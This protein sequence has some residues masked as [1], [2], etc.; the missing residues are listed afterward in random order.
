[1]TATNHRPAG[2]TW[3]SGYQFLGPLRSHEQ[4]IRGLPAT[5]GIASAR[6]C[7]TEWSPILGSTA[8]LSL[9]VMFAIY[10]AGYA[11]GR[12]QATLR[13]NHSACNTNLKP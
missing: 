9:V 13:F 3:R 12:D 6:H 5:A 8:S 7:S 10:A 11:G 4:R 1:M 2:I